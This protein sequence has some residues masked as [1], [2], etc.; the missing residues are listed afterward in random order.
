M[1]K[2]QAAQP[3]DPLSTLRAFLHQKTRH[4]LA[5]RCRDS[6]RCN[7]G[8]DIES[9]C[10]SCDNTYLFDNHQGKRPDF[11]VATIRSS[12]GLFHW[13]FIEMK[14]GGMDLPDLRDQLQAGAARVEQSDLP[15]PT[16]LDFIPLV[17]RGK[18]GLRVNDRIRFDRYKVSYRGAKRT[19]LIESCGAR[20]SEV[21][22]KSENPR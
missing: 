4:G 13:L 1:R 9:V 16:K 14:S 15:I 11:F 3:D 2:Q 12:D 10:I 6:G 17:L 21:L 7:L 18:G 5:D 19:V 20:L 8:L 22:R